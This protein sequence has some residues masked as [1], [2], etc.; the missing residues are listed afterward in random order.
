M[1]N[2]TTHR[3]RRPAGTLPG[4]LLALALGSSAAA[5]VAAAEDAPAALA[6]A[7][8]WPIDDFDDGDLVSASGLSW[9]VIADEQ[10]GGESH[11]DLELVPGAGGSGGALRLSA[12]LGGSSRG[13]YASVWAPFAPEGAPA[14][15]GGFRGLRFEARGTPGSYA[16]GVRGASARNYVGPFEVAAEWRRVEVRFADLVESP[17]VE[18]PV[19]LS[20]AELTWVGFGSGAGTPAAFELEIDRVEVFP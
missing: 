17:P 20:L 1:T 10:L 7:E 15:L 8:P 11:G 2:R 18:P 13:T 5:G 6:P 19:A 9:I 16:A 12:R 3:R 14:D 4:V